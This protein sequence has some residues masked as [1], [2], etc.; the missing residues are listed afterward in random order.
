MT[1]PLTALLLLGA[2]C[3]H[4]GSSEA[5]ASSFEVAHEAAAA[6]KKSV[7]ATTA[8]AARNTPAARQLEI[9]RWYC[10]TGGNNNAAGNV[11]SPPCEHLALVRKLAAAESAEERLA[12]E[13]QQA[14]LTGKGSPDW[15]DARALAR[16]CAG[17][18]AMRTAFCAAH[19]ASS[20]GG[21]SNGN[22]DGGAGLAC[23][24]ATLSK[25]YF[26]LASVHATNK[27]QHHAI[28]ALDSMVYHQ[29]LVE[30]KR[31]DATEEHA[32]VGH[33]TMQ[34]CDA[35]VRD[36]AHLFRGMWAA[37]VYIPPRGD[38]E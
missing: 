26:S 1:R 21:D 31:A 16:L 18:V 15:E 3:V 20:S 33:L 22:G 14:A 10:G 9:A 23:T 38:R 2:R 11:A 4:V 8:A 28:K 12:L 5:F 19:G 25:A 24:D 35:F 7:D 13:Q 6:S 30:H 34:K 32:K 36:S 37:Q 29:L 27:T 17:Y